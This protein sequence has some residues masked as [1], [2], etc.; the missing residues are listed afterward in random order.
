MLKSV[1]L[2]HILVGTDSLMNRNFKRTVFI[3]KMY[4]YYLLSFFYHV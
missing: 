1:A 3:W 4:H 2:L